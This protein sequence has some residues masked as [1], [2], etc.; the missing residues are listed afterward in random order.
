[1]FDILKYGAA[2]TVQLFVRVLLLDPL[3]LQCS[4]LKAVCEHRQ[5]DLPLVHSLRAANSELT[6]F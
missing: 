1:M 3:C 5:M 4:S 2:V 6:Q